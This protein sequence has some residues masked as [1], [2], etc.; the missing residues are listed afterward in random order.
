MGSADLAAR[1]LLPPLEVPV[2]AVTALVGGPC[3]L[4]LLGRSA[5]G[6]PA[7]GAAQMVAVSMTK[8]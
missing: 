1:T 2:G 3:L 8:R 5:A 7:Q 4:W 6:R